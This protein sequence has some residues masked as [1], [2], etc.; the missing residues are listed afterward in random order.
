L[1]A[2]GNRQLFSL[3]FENQEPQGWLSFG[4]MLPTSKRTCTLG[5]V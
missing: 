4:R 3:K 2:Q 5:P 1:Q